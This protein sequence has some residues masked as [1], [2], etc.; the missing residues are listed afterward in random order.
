MDVKASAN[1]FWHFVISSDHAVGIREACSLRE[2]L[3]NAQN[4]A[5]VTPIPIGPFVGP[6]V[7]RRNDEMTEVIADR[8]STA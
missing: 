1:E 4:R 3:V 7:V 6:N 5:L 8:G 2:K